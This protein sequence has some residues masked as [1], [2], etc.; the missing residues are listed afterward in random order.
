MPGLKSKKA[1][2]ESMAPFLFYNGSFMFSALETSRLHLAE[3]IPS[4]ARA[5]YSYASNPEITR[6]MG[7][8]THRSVGESELTIRWFMG[9]ARA[10]RA[11]CVGI[12][13]RD[14]GLF[15]GSTG[16][17][18]DQGPELAVTGWILRGDAHRQGYASE[19]VGAMMAQAFRL[20][21]KLMVFE[22][23]IHPDNTAS[24]RLALKLGMLDTGETRPLLAP[25]LDGMVHDLR[26]FRLERP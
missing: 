2:C 22:A 14:D 26:V 8:A 5:M 11:C 24:S 25:N 4:D 19:A 9:E 6:Y 17:G 20:W 10:Q 12:W 16:W 21:P 15:L 7:W 1:L 23:T 3:V 18:F 13:R